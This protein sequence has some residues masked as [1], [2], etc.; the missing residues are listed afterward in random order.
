MT[1]ALGSREIASLLC[2]D[3]SILR[4]ATDRI[5][6][7]NREIST[8]RLNKMFPVTASGTIRIRSP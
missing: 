5:A 7:A 8:G 1:G 6:K 3:F 2:P 4:T